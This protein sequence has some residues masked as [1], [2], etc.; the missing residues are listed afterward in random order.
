MSPAVFFYFKLD[1]KV[2]DAAATCSDSCLWFNEIEAINCL[3][4]IKAI[5]SEKYH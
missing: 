2:F 3:R 4:A 1:W 5:E